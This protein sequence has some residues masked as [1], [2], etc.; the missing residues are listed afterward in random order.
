MALVKCNECGQ[1][2]S[3]RAL[4]CPHCGAPA[5][6]TPSVAVGIVTALM[7]ALLFA[8][9]LASRAGGATDVPMIL[10]VAIGVGVLA[11]GLA[12]RLLLKLRSGR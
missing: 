3:S 9:L 12:I 10:V 5:S 6:G 7:G 4:K 2:V 8:G 1:Q 11:I